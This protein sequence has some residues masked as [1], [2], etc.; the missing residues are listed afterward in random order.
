MFAVA[1]DSFSLFV[2]WAKYPVECRA[3]EPPSAEGD[4][5]T[6]IRLRKLSNSVLI[7]F[8]KHVSE[9]LIVVWHSG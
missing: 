2:D 7:L 1:D 4:R 5:P 3:I 8:I 9:I 6:S